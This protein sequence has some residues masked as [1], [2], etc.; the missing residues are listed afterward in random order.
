[1]ASFEITSHLSPATSYPEETHPTIQVCVPCAGAQYTAA[2]QSEV[3]TTAVQQLGERD[4]LVVPVDQPHAIV[5]KRPAG[6]VSFQ[7]APAFV[8]H[9]VGVARLDL[10]DAFTTRDPFIRASAEQL[11]AEREPSPAFAEAI[12]T[13][14]AYR[15]SLASTTGTPLRSP[16]DAPPLA[17]RQRVAIESYI[18]AHLDR[19][20]ALAELASLVGLSQWH[21]MRR[22][23]ASHGVAPHGFITR[24]RVERARRLLATS[25]LPITR[26]ALAVGMSH[27]HFSR[28]F[29]HE[30]GVAPREFREAERGRTGP[31]VLHSD[32]TPRQ[33]AL[34]GRG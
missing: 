24:K 30:V 25:P 2:R 11:R 8:A 17:P 10:P 34:R 9:A 6:V 15:I 33:A 28:T 22:F 3:G 16:R 29:L 7:L 5:W 18:D 32:R 21:F 1:M 13:I 19:P 23:K 26:V 4:V 20:I 14:V 31:Q 27:S 12:A